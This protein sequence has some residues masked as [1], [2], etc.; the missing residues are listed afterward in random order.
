MASAKTAAAKAKKVATSK[1]AKKAAAG[2]V[3]GAGK[4]AFAGGV[5]GG[6]EALIMGEDFW[7]SARQGAFKGALTGA[8]GGGLF[9]GLTSSMRLG[10]GTRQ[11]VGFAIG[12]GM[13][14]T[15]GLIRNDFNGFNALL[16]GV[17]G[18]IGASHGATG[19]VGF[20]ADVA[21]S[22]IEKIAAMLL[23]W[24]TTFNKEEN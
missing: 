12:F 10:I 19:L 2:A 22:T 17:F 15:V 1:A 9:G 4:G 11:I 13:N 21:I 24:L 3:K 8:I 16:G 14:A 20:G 18:F 6:V 23:G 7:V 5:A